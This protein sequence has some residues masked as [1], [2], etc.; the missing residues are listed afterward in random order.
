MFKKCGFSLLLVALIFST[1]CEKE[2][3]K[4]PAAEQAATAAEVSFRQDLMPIFTRSCA[5][6]HNRESSNKAAIAEEV[7]YEKPEDILVK[8]GMYIIPEKPAESGLLEIVAQ[9]MAVGDHQLL[10][11]PPGT[12]VPKWSEKEI[13]LFSQWIIAGAQDN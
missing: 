6:C 11:P 3:V 7:Y 1:G 4:T 10:M 9:K 5:V 12:A 13:G 8:V 2:E